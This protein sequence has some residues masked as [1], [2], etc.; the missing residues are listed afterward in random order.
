MMDGLLLQFLLVAAD[1]THPGMVSFLYIALDW[2]FGNWDW[3]VIGVFILNLSSS[4]EF[5]QRGGQLTKLMHTQ[6]N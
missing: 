4:L 5:G 1:T 3:N 6:P 2:E